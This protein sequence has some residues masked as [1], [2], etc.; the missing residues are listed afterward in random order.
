MRY[1]APG[2]NC[3]D[4]EFKAIKTIYIDIP[5]LGRLGI[6]RAQNLRC[7]QSAVHGEAAREPDIPLTIELRR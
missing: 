3:L 1:T 4:L 7:E 6:G 2:G 5:A